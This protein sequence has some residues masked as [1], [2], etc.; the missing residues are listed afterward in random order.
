MNKCVTR[1]KWIL[2]TIPFLVSAIYLLI[3]Y[4]TIVYPLN[5]QLII[6]MFLYL[7]PPAGKESMVPAGVILLKQYYGHLSVP[8]SATS[9]AFVDFAVA[10][11]MY[12]NWDIVEKIPVL[13]KWLIK[14]EEKQR[15]RLASKKIKKDIAFV[16]LALFV[17]FPFQGTG[18]MGGTV[19]GRLI[20]LSA[21]ETLVTIVAGSLLGCY[22]IA[23]IAYFSVES[24]RIF[25]ET[26]NIFFLVSVLIFILIF[27][28]FFYF[29]YRNLRRVANSS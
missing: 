25:E 6:I 4:F 8:I 23:S 7:V 10:L 17:A 16:F 26:Q 21:K 22:L 11:F 5:N 2:R 19:V 28:L 1:E 15:S 20:G 29:I 27:G 14:F 12:Y 9:M 3:I 24:L 13:G 18:G